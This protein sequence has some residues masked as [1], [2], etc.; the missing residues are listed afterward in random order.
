MTNDLQLS[1]KRLVEE[2]RQLRA[3]FQREMLTLRE[4]FNREI[5]Q[6]AQQGAR[7]SVHLETVSG[8]LDQVLDWIARQ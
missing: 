2:Q 1:V 7:T 5:R 4:D 8:K 3:D 6:L